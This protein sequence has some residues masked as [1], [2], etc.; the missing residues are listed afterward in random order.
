MRPDIV[1][2]TV[3]EDTINC[4]SIATVSCLESAVLAADIACFEA[5]GNLLPKSAEAA[6]G[7]LVSLLQADHDELDLVW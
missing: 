3:L 2:T 4:I 6:D 5:L 7:L 1:W